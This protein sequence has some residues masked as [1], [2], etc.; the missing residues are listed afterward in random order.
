VKTL[1]IAI[2][3]TLPLD[4]LMQP[5]FLGGGRGSGK[6]SG[7][8]TLFEAAYDAEAQCIAIA[9][10]GKWWSLRLAADG[11]GNGLERVYVFGG[12]H[13]DL[14]LTSESGATIARLCVERRIHAVL[15]VSLLRK[16]E[17]ARFL[18]AFLEEFWLLKKV[19]NDSYPVVLFIEEA[20]AVVPQRP[21]PDEARMLGAAEDLVREGRNHGIGVV[22]LDQRSAV[23]NKNVLA[24]VEVLI[25]LRTIHHLDRKT[26]GEWIV[27][28]G[29]ATDF[30]GQLPSMKAGEAYLYA[31]VLEI[32]ERITMR[33]PRTFNATATA[34]VGERVVK[35]GALTQV[36]VGALRESLAQVIA[37]AEKNDPKALK[38][39]IAALKAELA[40]K[41]AAAAAP[42]KPVEVP[43]SIKEELE[44]LQRS[45]EV[46]AKIGDQLAQKQQVVVG[47]LHNATEI[48]KP[49]FERPMRKL[50]VRPPPG[51]VVRSARPGPLPPAPHLPAAIKVA[52]AKADGLSMK[53]TEMLRELVAVICADLPALSRD[54]WAMRSGLRNNGNFRNYVSEL[55]TAGYLDEGQ[56]LPNN[57][58]RA[59]VSLGGKPPAPKT[60][61]ELVHQWLPMLSAKAAAMFNALL[62][63]ARQLSRDELAAAV[64][65]L[66]NGNF[67]NYMSEL[68]T[69]NLLSEARGTG[70]GL[71][72]ALYLG[73]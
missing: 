54:D 58:G 70:V 69:A 29:G 56:D 11:K 73:D 67:R 66:N 10:T 51:V 39:E 57:A 17:R 41:P 34:S 16:G 5:V 4:I 18:A 9:P 31:P 40:K 47:A 1:D 72:P 25:V 63:E 30:V 62:S 37:E 68:N 44:Q 42:A 26:Y 38:R 46:M 64:Q 20:H 24:L 61:N 21:Q 2:G 53:A 23:V 7:A 50:E 65:L 6:T 27:E 13:G 59:I 45:I 3:K 36:D 33:M 48:L 14:P 15:D 55:R 8:K 49:T 19:E 43:V 71:N 12:P 60:S 35:A 52:I 32:F 22:L 28:K